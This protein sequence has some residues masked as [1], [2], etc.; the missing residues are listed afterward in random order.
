MQ[1]KGAPLMLSSIIEAVMRL[2]ALHCML[3]WLQPP[4]MLMSLQHVVL[5]CPWLWLSLSAPC[6]GLVESL[7]SSQRSLL[8]VILLI[9]TVSPVL[10]SRHC[11]YQRRKTGNNCNDLARLSCKGTLCHERQQCVISPVSIGATSLK[12]ICLSD[13]WRR[14]HNQCELHQC[15]A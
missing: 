5:Q 8:P 2:S 1:G 4:L 15:N 7:D 11:S 14:W 6:V 3:Q 12:R 9:T 10:H 13:E